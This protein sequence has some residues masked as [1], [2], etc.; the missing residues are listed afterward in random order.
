MFQ[1]PLAGRGSRGKPIINLLSMDADE[2]ISAILPVKSYDPDKFVFMAT[3]K[4]TVKKISLEQFSRPRNS[5][6]IAL[7]LDE[8]DHLVSVALTDADQDVMLFSNA[9][10]VIRFKADAV[11]AMGRT[12]RGVRGIKLTA[13]Q[14]V[15]SLVVVAPEGAILTATEQGYGK[16]TLVDEYRQTGRGGQGVISIQVNERNGQVVGAC[17]VVDNDEVMLITNGG[18]M[19]RT[20]VNEI[21]IV[22][23]NTQGVILIRLDE[24]E[25]LAGLQAIAEIDTPADA[26][27][28][29]E[30]PSPENETAS[31]DD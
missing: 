8:G 4:G 3:H 13:D 25:Q 2:K 1:L 19:V 9:G 23:R 5:G 21:S 27:A 30:Q 31:N 18:T 24:G 7:A 28:T 6:I 17:Q 20:R 14:Y 12:A 10:K 29:D 26:E 15:I 11:R 22:G 16:R